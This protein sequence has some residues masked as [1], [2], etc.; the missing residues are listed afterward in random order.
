M[1]SW[2]IGKTDSLSTTEVHKKRYSSHSLDKYNLRKFTITLSVFD[3]DKLNQA[4]I[5]ELTTI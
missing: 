1:D 2:Q 3:M 5:I 4:R